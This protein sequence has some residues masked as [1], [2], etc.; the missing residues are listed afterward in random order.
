MEFY[1][2]EE[3]AVQQISQLNHHVK[4]LN[5]ALHYA[6]IEAQHERAALNQS[7][8]HLKEMQTGYE[9]SELARAKCENDLHEERQEHR[10]CQEA[11]NHERSRHEE[12]E[13]NMNCIWNAHCRL[14][15]MLSKAHFGVEEDPESEPLASVNVSELILELEAKAS[16]IE[17]LEFSTNLLQRNIENKTREFEE[18]LRNDALQHAGDAVSKNRIIDEQE[19]LIRRNKAEIVALQE[20]VNRKKNKRGG[21]KWRK[22]KGRQS[23]VQR[24]W[25]H[26]H[27]NAVNEDQNPYFEGSFLEK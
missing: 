20:S 13:K 19:G 10:M 6:G 17:D 1:K 4:Q 11:L 5:D 2:K 27:W 14:G 25:N 9:S 15:D 24:D 3:L 8:E 7:H 18:K 21:K 22:N 23:K 16:K 12:T 26:Q